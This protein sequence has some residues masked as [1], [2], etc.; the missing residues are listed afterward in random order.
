MNAKAPSRLRCIGILYA[1]E[2]FR[3]KRNPAALMAAGLIILMA[4]LINIESKKAVSAKRAESA[5][6]EVVFNEEDAL[7]AHLREHK[8]ADKL[9]FRKTDNDLFDEKADYANSVFCAVEISPEKTINNTPHRQ[10]RFRHKG[11]QFNALNKLARITL[12][13]LATY[14]GDQTILQSIEKIESINSA[15]PPTATIDLAS[16]QSKAMVGA[17]ILFSAQF[18]LCC[19]LFISFTSHERER[20]VLQSLALTHA[21]PMDLFLAKVLFHLSLSLIACVIILLILK[22]AIFSSL[23]FSAIVVGILTASSLGLICIASIICSLIRNQTTASLVG[24]CYIMLMGVIFALSGP[25]VAFRVIRDLMFE[26]HSI[27][28]FVALLSPMTEQVFFRA[29]IHALA[30]LIV[31]SFLTLIS[32]LIWKKH[33]VRS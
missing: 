9:R 28:L 10:V 29:S 5:P 2:W 21:S 17:M 15:P 1:K 22:P 12:H 6:C 3:L 30:L 33:T 11:K 26:H 7:I 32:C 23:V 18:F 16:N 31:I 13:S 25:F 8:L 4:F 20:G 19:A 14:R 24:F 27:A